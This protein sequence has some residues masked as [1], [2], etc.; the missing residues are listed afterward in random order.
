MEI[1]RVYCEVELYFIYFCIHFRLQMIKA[2]SRVLL[3]YSNAGFL[4]TEDN[5]AL[6]LSLFH[7]H[8]TYRRVSITP[9][10]L[11]P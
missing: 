3:T 2:Y 9:S 5:L 10:P 4:L 7:I 1:Q 6:E 11:A 8:I